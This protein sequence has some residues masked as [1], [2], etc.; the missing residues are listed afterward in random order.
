V[1]TPADLS[2]ED[3]GLVWGKIP[4]IQQA[5]NTAGFGLN[6]NTALALRVIVYL[7]EVPIDRRPTLDLDFDVLVNVAR[8][9]Q[10]MLRKE[11]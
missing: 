4:V 5:L 11:H 3:R 1:Q 10:S 6:E 7:C 8:S 9:E 2:D